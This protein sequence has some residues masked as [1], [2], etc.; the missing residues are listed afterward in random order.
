MIQSLYSV[1]RHIVRRNIG[2]EGPIAAG[3]QSFLPLSEPT[4][5]ILVSLSPGKK[6]GYAILKDVEALSQ[7]KLV[8]STSTLYDALERMLRQGLILRV[9]ETCAAP[10]GRERKSYML[11][12]IGRRVL[13]A[14]ARRLKTMLELAATSLEMGTL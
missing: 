12:E 7:G 3:I 4:F 1:R 5:Y 8:L 10:N 11:T 2:G 6:H 14:E 9:G 13:A